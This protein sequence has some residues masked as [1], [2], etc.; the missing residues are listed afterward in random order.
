MTSRQGHP[1]EV[2]VSLLL[3]IRA[4][5]NK[6]RPLV[7]FSHTYPERDSESLSLFYS[8]TKPSS[9]WSFLGFSRGCLQWC[10]AKER[11]V[12]FLVWQTCFEWA[13][14]LYRIVPDQHPS[15]FL[16]HPL[17]IAE[18]GRGLQTLQAVGVPRIGGDEDA[19]AVP[20]EG[21]LTRVGGGG[22]W[23]AHVKVIDGSWS[24]QS[25]S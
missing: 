12:K 11:G 18:L 20:G 4:G 1:F 3:T 2:F 16:K 10:R 8:G 13:T 14:S 22:D 7:K 6:E 9:H 21:K 15:W 17:L 5:P 19:S 25:H 23:A 24:S